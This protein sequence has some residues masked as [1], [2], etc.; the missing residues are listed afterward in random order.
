[1][2]ACYRLM[3][4]D[5]LAEHQRKIALPMMEIETEYNKAVFEAAC[6]NSSKAIGHL[7]SALEK[8]QAGVSG[9]RREPNLDSI[10]DDPEYHNLLGNT[11]GK[12]E[13]NKF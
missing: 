2:V 6:G 11:F 10:R 8:K 3:G 12:K 13:I 7:V 5:N 1:M 9:M 4:K